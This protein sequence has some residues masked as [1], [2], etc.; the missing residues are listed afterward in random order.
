MPLV[1]AVIL[2]YGYET[3]TVK[4]HL[5]LLLPSCCGFFALGTRAALLVDPTLLLLGRFSRLAAVRS[6]RLH[7][8]RRG[9]LRAL[10]RGRLRAGA[11]IPARR[12]A[13]KY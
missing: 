7:S 6:G 1:E 12:Y 11:L 3:L 8:L 10:R 5:R 13:N 2:I 9:R 4:A